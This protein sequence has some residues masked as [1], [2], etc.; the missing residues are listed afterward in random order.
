M[1]YSFGSKR[2][3]RCFLL[4]RKGKL[5]LFFVDT[6]VEIPVMEVHRLAVC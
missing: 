1:N 4:R 2:A 6:P 3:V 5:F